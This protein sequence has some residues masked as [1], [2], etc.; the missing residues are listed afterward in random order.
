MIWNVKRSVFLEHK[1]EIIRRAKTGESRKSIYEDMKHKMCG[2]SKSYF[3]KMFNS[4][5]GREQAAR[6]N[7]RMAKTQTIVTENPE[8]VNKNTRVDIPMGFDD[9]EMEKI[10]RGKKQR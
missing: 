2:I 10:Y 8:T 6:L 4:Y 5:I 7:K 3:Y 9:I 1:A